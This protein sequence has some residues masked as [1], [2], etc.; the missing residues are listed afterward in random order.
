MWK[1][2]RTEGV[3]ALEGTACR[4]ASQEALRK[5]SVLKTLLGA[6]LSSSNLL[7]EKQP[8]D[9]DVTLPKIETSVND[10]RKSLL[11]QICDTIFSPWEWKEWKTIAQWVGTNLYT[12]L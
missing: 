11:Q 1:V 6:L 2:S 3:H 4:K 7:A 9:V 5:A 12:C 8:N 10:T